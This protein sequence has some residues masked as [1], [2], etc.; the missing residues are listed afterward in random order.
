MNKRIRGIIA[1]LG[2]ATAAATG[3]T[4]AHTQHVNMDTTW[5]AGDGTDDTTWGAPATTDDTTWGTPPKDGD[6]GGTPITP[7]DTTWG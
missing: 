6:T 2:L 4:I 5:G 7:L 3:I 1:T